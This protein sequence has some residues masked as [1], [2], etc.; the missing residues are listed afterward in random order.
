[1]VRESSSR[2]HHCPTNPLPTQVHCPDQTKPSQCAISNDTCAIQ[3][4][5]QSKYSATYFTSF[6]K[7]T[8]SAKKQQETLCATTHPPPSSATIQSEISN[9][10]PLF[11]TRVSLDIAKDEEGGKHKTLATA[12]EAFCT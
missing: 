4:K 10:F 2:P 9:S 7:H 12:K 8:Y 5:E 11:R 6:K 3:S 1:M